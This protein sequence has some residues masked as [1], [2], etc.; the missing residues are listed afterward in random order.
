MPDPQQ[1]LIEAATRPLADNAEMQLAATHLLGELTETNPASAEE[2]ISRWEVLD[3]KKRKPVWRILLFSLLLIISATVLSIGAYSAINFRQA[4]LL[5]TGYSSDAHL[6]KP[7]KS[8]LTEEEKLILYGDESQPS[9]AG[10]AKGLWDRHPENPAYF[11]RYAEAYLSENKKLP[12]D[13][14]LQARRIDPQNAW[15][16][17]I[18]AGVEAKDCVKKKTQSAKA[19]A[20]REAP[21]WEVLDQ[22]RLERALRL[23]REARDLS[24]CNDYEFNLMREKIP[25]L[26]QGNQTERL[27]STGHL[28]G[29]TANGLISTRRIGDTIAAKASLLAKDKNTA[30]FR[31]LMADSD[32]L[33]RKTLSIKPCT[34]VAGLVFRGNVSTSS[35]GL[36]AGA[37]ELGIHP[38]AERHQAIYDRLHEEREARKKRRLLIEG[39]EFQRK[40]GYLAGVVTPTVNRQVANPPAIPDAELRPGRLM[41]HEIASMLCAEAAFLLLGIFL[42]LVLAFRFRQGTMTHRLARR[43]E[44]LLLPVDWL[45][46]LGFGIILPFSFVIILNRFTPLGGR[47]LS[48]YGLTFVL[49]MAHFFALVLLLLIVPILIARWRLAKR[50]VSFGFDWSKSWIGWSAVI[51]TIFYIVGIGFM[52]HFKSMS[53]VAAV[54]AFLILPKIW[55]LA[56]AARA[57]LAKSASLLM[58]STI[59]RV[60]VPAYASAMLIMI[61]LVPVF[62][63]AGQYWFKRDTFMKLDPSSPG[64]GTYEYK[65]AVQLQ[66]ELREILGYD[67]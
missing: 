6:R 18:A 60:L 46:I 37:R 25:L 35:Q 10:K 2:A 21:E 7:G 27:I 58:S 11:A 67:G 26:A 17:Y 52:P 36:A 8:T 13:F 23:V 31:E 3:S 55:L 19:K 42:V 32:A 50:A 5:V 63:A 40:A 38:E 14:L 34:L 64:M 47:D 59:A 15:F 43:M 12:E 29:I 45:L 1:R 57:L 66:K 4:F 49:P 48:I 54:T 62:N 41:D 9:K 28:A 16:L 30:G 44:S 39:V 53:T 22:D 56:I 61:S 51:S 65:V 33:S 20:A 24:F